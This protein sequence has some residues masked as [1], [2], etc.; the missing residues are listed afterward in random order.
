MAAGLQRSVPGRICAKQ[1]LLSNISW[2]SLALIFDLIKIALIPLTADCAA[3]LLHAV[4]R[5]NAVLGC[6]VKPPRT[7]Q[8]LTL[9]SGALGMMV[10]NTSDSTMDFIIHIDIAPDQVDG[11]RCRKQRHFLFPP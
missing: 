4:W 7:M 9:A 5:E 6:L 1:A 3:A 10:R 8:A 11:G 2:T